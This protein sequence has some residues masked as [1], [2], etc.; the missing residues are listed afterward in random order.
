[1]RNKEFRK[2][3]YGLEPETRGNYT[4]IYG[5]RID[6]IYDITNDVF[7]YFIFIDDIFSPTDKQLEITRKY[8][9]DCE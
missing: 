1:M 9:L 5:H 2:I 4:Y 6:I 3:L 8:I 7:V